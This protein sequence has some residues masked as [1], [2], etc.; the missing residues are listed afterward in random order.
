MIMPVLAGLSDSG[1]RIRMPAFLLDDA[2][3]ADI[4]NYVRNA[5]NDSR[6]ARAASLTERRPR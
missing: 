2:T 1:G 6:G 3:I 4:A 5:M